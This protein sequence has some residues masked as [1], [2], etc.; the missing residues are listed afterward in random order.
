M[1]SQTEKKKWKMPH[2]WVIIGVLLLV[3]TALTYII[4][5]GSFQRYMDET[6]G[7][8]IVDATSF[9]LSETST[10]V[11][12]LRIPYLIVT[13]CVSQGSIIFGIILIAGA[14]EIVLHTGMFQVFCNKLSRICSVG[15]REK[16]FILSLIHIL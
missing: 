7:K 9:A 8:T 4:P 13:S 14:L 16:L 2:G 12:F 10:P 1:K 6:T 5:A 11:S 15:G 3:V